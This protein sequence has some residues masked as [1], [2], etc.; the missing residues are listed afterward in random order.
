MKKK[1][2]S[3]LLALAMCLSLLPVTAFAAKAD[4]PDWYFL[5]AIFKNVD[6]DVKDGYGKT[7]H[8]TYS[9]PEEEVELIR[10]LAVE[11]EEYMNS[12]G[13]MRAHVEVVEIDQPV[14][15]FYN[16]SEV[17]GS[18]LRAAEAA[19]L[20]ESKVD[21]DRYDHVT[22][23]LNLTVW[24]LYAG[25]TSSPFE[26]GT[27]ISC[28]NHRNWEHLESTYRA[29][30]DKNFW[31]LQLYV[32]EFLHFGEYLNN[33]WGGKFV[34][35]REGKTHYVRT[36]D[37]KTYYT[38]AI[39]NRINEPDVFPEGGTGM[40][41]AVWQ[42]PPHVIRTMTELNVPSSVTS[43]G[44]FAFVNNTKLTRVSIPSSVTNIEGAAFQGC[45]N[46]RSI[47]LPATITKVE[48]YTFA[49]CISLTD[50]YYGG[51]EAQ[52]KAIP[53]GVSNSALG[54]ATIHYNH[55][56]ADVK[57]GDWFAEPV[58]W[59][60]EN[61]VTNGTG[62]GK[63]SPDEDCTVAQI[64][65]FLWRA[66][67]SPEPAGG[68]PFSDVKGGDWY[69]DAAAWAYE[70]GMVSG[71]TLGVNTPCTRAMA[72]TYLWKAAGSPSAKAAGF[73]DVPANA[74]YARAVDWAVENGVTKGT[75][76]AT[77]SPGSTCTRGEIVTFLYR[78]PG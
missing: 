62:N 10:D 59:A 56:M 78:A 45:S 65:T 46:L 71:K 29:L 34:L 21:L 43:I 27:G 60:L 74:D 58:A 30:T 25:I 23:F 38:D 75:G 49:N 77:F 18:Y 72:V 53:I 51:S 16:E 70:K 12:V 11:F 66:N 1:L 4:L 40:H 54:R 22:C 69:A 61:G 7:Q 44:K 2:S 31:H 76:A 35:H 17:Q 39:L 6:A 33:K 57:T 64:L 48:V 36:D 63:F 20:L 42:Y 15:E 41:P 47:S 13:V 28:V 24:T 55:L 5:F 73:T 8:A 26:N 50:V 19:P 3:L 37:W 68:N 52:W 14:T 9:M 67:G 32:H